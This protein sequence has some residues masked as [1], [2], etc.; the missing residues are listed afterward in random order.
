[1]TDADEVA[2]EKRELEMRKR[3]DEKFQKFC[4][5]S[6]QVASKYGSDL[7]FDVPFSDLMFNGCPA[8]SAVNMFPTKSSLV[9]LQEAPFFV[10]SMK[11]I[12]L[13]HFER[14]SLAV[15]NF[16]FVLIYKDYA[17][18]KRISS[19]PMESLAMIKDWLDESNIIF[20]EGPISLN[21]Q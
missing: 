19:V 2:E 16:D 6:E 17:N 5:Q 1:M 11:D 15:K 18:F 8:K 12:E 10:T 20:T 9:A 14:V 3:L 21:W 13:V 4:A 7:E